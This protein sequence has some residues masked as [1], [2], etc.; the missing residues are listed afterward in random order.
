[1]TVSLTSSTSSPLQGARS[2]QSR[3]PPGK[4]PPKAGGGR[5]SHGDA[6]RTLGSELSEE[7][8]EEMLEAVAQL[9]EDG[10]SFE[11]IKSYVDSELEARGVDSGRP[12]QLLNVTA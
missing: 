7:E 1:M 5:P 3:P 6:I 2:A 11:D 9:Q 4:G 10:A 8:Q 12:G